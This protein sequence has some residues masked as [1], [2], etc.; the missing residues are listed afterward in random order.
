[1]EAPAPPEGAMDAAML[2][3]GMLPAGMLAG[4]DGA[5]V[6][7]LTLGVAPGLQAAKRPATMARPRTSR[8]MRTPRAE[9]ARSEPWGRPG[10]AS[11]GGTVD[12]AAERLSGTRRSGALQLARTGPTRAHSSRPRNAQAREGAPDVTIARRR[13][14]STSGG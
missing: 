1:M 4:S 14:A 10:R 11:T 2:A 12:A 8:F 3:A 13:R 6:T 9:L 7:T 5:G